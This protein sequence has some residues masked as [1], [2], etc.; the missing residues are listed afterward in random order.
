MFSLDKG[1][2]LWS[3]EVKVFDLSGHDSLREAGTRIMETYY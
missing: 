1:G 3:K 2:I